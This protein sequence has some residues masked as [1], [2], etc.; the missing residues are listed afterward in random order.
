VAD[1]FSVE[2]TPIGTYASEI[3]NNGGA[4]IV[5]HDPEK[6]RL[7]VVNLADVSID[8]LSIKN[9]TAPTLLFSISVA[10]YGN[11][12]NSVDVQ[13]KVVAAAVQNDVKTDSGKV[14]FFDTDGNF[15]SAVTVGALPDMITFTPDGKK[16]L[17]AN[18]GEP[19]DAYTIDPEGSVSIID[20]SRGAAKVTQKDVITASFRAFNNAV[21]DPSIRVYGPHATVAQDLEPEY[22]TV[23]SNSK[24][25]WVT[26]QESNAIGV[27][28][29]KKG[30]FTKLIG[31]GVKGHTLL[32]NGLDASDRDT[33]INIANWP[34][35]G[36]FLPDAIANFRFSGETFLV[37]ANEGDAR[38]YPGF[39]EEARV[40]EL[41][42]DPVVFPNAATLKQNTALGR[43]RVTNANGDLNHD[44]KFEELFSLGARSFSIW[45][46]SGEL[47]YD[48]GEDLE[49]KTASAL[50]T[51][52][53]SNNDANNS[54]DTRSDDKGPEP[55]GVTL[56]QISGHIYA[57]VC[58]ERI[59]G[60]MVYEV[61]NPYAPQFVQYVNNRNFAGNP[62]AGTAGDLGPEGLH[63]VE[64]KKSP[65]GSPL[66][67]V[68][69]EISG[70]TTIFQISRSPQ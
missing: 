27:L 55:E 65:N 4:E 2:L 18:E 67:L 31:L 28:D 48:S 40:N 21:L 15:L 62:A 13:G 29:L 50:P 6:Q 20:L 36:M 46:T 59:G 22:I 7:F 68:A 37:T 47:V 70:T 14:V 1:D 38:A 24:E 57:F 69:N 10:P 23:A 25:A 11:Q 34:V 30:A 17:V 43:L 9:P 44:G 52:F 42:L 26:L 56:G 53:N 61:T 19:N 63:F 64:G 66:L 33:A 45:T 32:G 35:K 54:F 16:V 12:A 8:V 51:V 3:F 49:R 41:T 58:L 5:A 39:N 60:I